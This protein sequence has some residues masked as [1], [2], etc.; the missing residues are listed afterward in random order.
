MSEE[1][2]SPPDNH[3]GF[4]EPSTTATGGSNPTH[5][6]NDGTPRSRGA[7]PVG[8]HPLQKI[9]HSPKNLWLVVFGQDCS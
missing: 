5:H 7:V 4:A 8:E 9:Y 1:K 3:P 6:K 2:G